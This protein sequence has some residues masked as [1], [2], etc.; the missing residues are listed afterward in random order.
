[1]ARDRVAFDLLLA[2]ISIDPEIETERRGLTNCDL[3]S[4]NTLGRGEDRLR[5]EGEFAASLV[6]EDVGCV[7]LDTERSSRVGVLPVN[8][9]RLVDA[10]DTRMRET[11]W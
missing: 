3:L 8:D 1:M 2:R 11:Y 4:R 7:D 9:H 5:L 6:D 10:S